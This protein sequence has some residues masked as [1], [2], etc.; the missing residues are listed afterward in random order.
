VNF[1]LLFDIGLCVLLLGVA[2]AAIAARELFASISLFI[3]FGLLVAIGWV[4]IDALNVALTGMLLLNA[5]ARIEGAAQGRLPVRLLPIL[6]CTMIAAALGWSIA[7]LAAPA[8]GLVPLVERNLPAAGVDNA[9]TA[10]L[11]NFRGWDTLLETVLLVVALIGIWSL[12]EDAVWR[13]RPGLDQ[14]VRPDGVLATFGRFLPPLGFLFGAYLV[15]VGSSAPGGAFQ[16]ATVLAVMWVLMMVA[17]LSE[18]PSVGSRGFRWAL[19]SG[20]LLFL[21]MGL[22][23]IFHGGFLFFP[24]NFA[25]EMTLLIELGLAVSVALTL[26]LL[27]MGAPRRP[28]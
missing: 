9:V 1:G 4:R 16:G 12:G 22:L 13:G 8:E 15:W 7:E 23:G 5:S 19:A 25:Q 11:I 21:A 3:G 14:T 26:G 28:A 18:P 10:A 27:L 6:L 17:G 20:P 24:P 2:F